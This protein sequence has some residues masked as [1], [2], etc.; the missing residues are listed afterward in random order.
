MRLAAVVRSAPVGSYRDFCLVRCQNTTC[1]T[2]ATGVCRADLVVSAVVA[3][4]SLLI[5]LSFDEATWIGIGRLVVDHGRILYDT[6][7]DNKLPGLYLVI[8]AI[9]LLPG[10]FEVARSAAMGATF[11]LVTVA[12]ARV[13]VACGPRIVGGLVAVLASGLVVTTEL[14]AVV[15]LAWS[16]VYAKERRRWPLAA[17]LLIAGNFDPRAVVFG[18]SILDVCW[19]RSDRSRLIL[20]I[21]ALVGFGLSAALF[22]MTTPHVRSALIEMNL[23]SRGAITGRSLL[24]GVVVLI[25]VVLAL[26]ESRSLNARVLLFLA[27]VVAVALVSR[28]PFPHYWTYGALAVGLGSSDGMS[29]TTGSISE[30]IKLLPLVALVPLGA[31]VGGNAV[32]QDR[33]VAAYEQAAARVTELVGPNENFAQ[34]AHAPYA[35]VFSGAPIALD[36]PGTLY[37]RWVTPGSSDYLASIERRLVHSAVIVDDGGLNVPVERIEVGLR[38][39]RRLLDPLVAEYT[40]VETVG[41]VSIRYAPPCR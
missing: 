16:V 26:R 11:W 2:L 40:C 23:A 18:M 35:Y 1:T 7:I 34:F 13:G 10:M 17:A 41:H 4:F 28:A 20:P 31:L 9:D 39:L 12:L 3:A 32:V 30:K 8:A 27:M 33:D 15:G 29:I 38:P 6:A 19:P 24:V 22:V 37:L 14:L 5:P 21:L 25:P 36:A